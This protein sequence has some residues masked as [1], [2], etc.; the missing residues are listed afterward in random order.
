MAAE[1]NYCLSTNKIAALPPV[2]QPEYKLCYAPWAH[3]S[4]M[5]P[6]E[7]PVK[8]TQRNEMTAIHVVGLFFVFFIKQSSVEEEKSTVKS[9]FEILTFSSLM[10]G[11]LSQPSWFL[12]SSYHFKKGPKT[13]RDLDYIHS[14]T[15]LLQLK[16][17]KKHLLS[18]KLS[19]EYKLQDVYMTK[20]T[21][22]P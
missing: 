20:D 17:K 16:S 6:C 22:L 10:S 21:Q 19:I 7:Q 9:L 12:W 15:L 5:G 2:T 11:S 4:M 18:V 1:W 14:L 13:L 3:T 8:G